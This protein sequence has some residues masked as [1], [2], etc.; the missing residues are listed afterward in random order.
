MRLTRSSLNRGWQWDGQAGI[1]PS[2]KQQNTLAMWL[3]FKVE[4]LFSLFYCP[5]PPSSSANVTNLL[6]FKVEVLFSLFYCLQCAEWPG[7]QWHSGTTRTSPQSVRWVMWVSFTSHDLLLVPNS[8]W[9]NL[10]GQES[11]V[12]YTL[13]CYLV[14]THI[15]SIPYIYCYMAKSHNCTDYIYP[16]LLY[17]TKSWNIYSPMLYDRKSWVTYT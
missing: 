3:Y 14:R 15:L 1:K 8:G 12:M 7:A 11:Y 5:P 4:V 17:G 2:N 13:Y 9:I 10:D 16:T 6:H